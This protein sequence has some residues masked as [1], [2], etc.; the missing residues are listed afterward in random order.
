MESVITI[1]F[2]WLSLFKKICQNNHGNL[3]TRETCFLLYTSGFE[4]HDFC[5][6]LFS[7]LLHMRFWKETIQ[8]LGEYCLTDIIT[9]F[10][11]NSTCSLVLW[12]EPV[13][14]DEPWTPSRLI[15]IVRFRNIFLI[16]LLGIISSI[17]AKSLQ[18]FYFLFENLFCPYFG[19]RI[20][21]PL[22][23]LFLHS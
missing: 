9:F 20:Y 4:L 8:Y 12:L 13:R 6:G 18:I 7:I 1:A 3:N 23:L 5:H 10:E 2:Y 16:L 17:C 15:R 22:S 11:V 14:V 19:S 21:G